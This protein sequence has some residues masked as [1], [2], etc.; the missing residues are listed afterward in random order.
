MLKYATSRS[1]PA[2]C[3]RPH[4]VAAVVSREVRAMRVVGE[5]QRL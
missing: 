3:E 5:K 2:P 4:Q 1:L